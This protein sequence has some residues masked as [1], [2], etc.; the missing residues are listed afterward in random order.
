MNGRFCKVL[1]GKFN[2]VKDKFLLTVD[3]FIYMM[4]TCMLRLDFNADDSGE[5]DLLN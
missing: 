2:S 1:V 3:G 5:K 4:K